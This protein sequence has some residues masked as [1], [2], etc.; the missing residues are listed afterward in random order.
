[1]TDRTSLPK[2][3]ETQLKSQLKDV[4]A[5]HRIFSWPVTAGIASYK[6]APDRVLHLGPGKGVAYLEAK[7]P[8]GRQSEHQ[9]AFDNQCAVDGV[10]YLLVHSVEELEQKLKGLT[11]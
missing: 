11:K 6:G 1:M 4:L 10:P 9:K 8:N 7:L 2:M 3:T 5:I